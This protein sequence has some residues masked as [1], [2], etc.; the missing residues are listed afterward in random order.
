MT[1]VRGIFC[2]NNVGKCVLSLFQMER[3]IVWSNAKSESFSQP[4]ESAPEHSAPTPA[5]Y[6][7]VSKPNWKFYSRIR[8]CPNFNRDVTSF[9][10]WSFT[11]RRNLIHF[12]NYSVEESFVRRSYSFGQ[13]TVIVAAC[14][15]M[16]KCEL[17]VR[18]E[19]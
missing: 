4:F 11:I 14:F 9:G 12:Y 5:I 2:E 18:I 6:E 10:M 19:Q 1:E 8:G 13:S 3:K 15:R 16:E 17:G 7:E